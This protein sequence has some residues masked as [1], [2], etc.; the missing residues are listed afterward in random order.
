MRVRGSG[1][2]SAQPTVIYSCYIS[3]ETP[4]HG[5]WFQSFEKRACFGVIFWKESWIKRSELHVFFKT[6]ELFRKDAKSDFMVTR[7]TISSISLNK[8]LWYWWPYFSI[9]YCPYSYCFGAQFLISFVQWHT[10]FILRR[11]V[12]RNLFLTDVVKI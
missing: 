3:F 10:P 1:V 6:S 11:D 2:T 9:L 4:I 8:L 12:T 7:R 5:S